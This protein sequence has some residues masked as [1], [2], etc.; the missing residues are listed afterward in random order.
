MAEVTVSGTPL[1]MLYELLVED[2]WRAA[3]YRSDDYQAARDQV[4]IIE[5]IGQ[6]LDREA[7]T[8]QVFAPA[9]ARFNNLFPLDPDDATTDG[10]LRNGND[11]AVHIATGSEASYISLPG[12]LQQFLDR[13]TITFMQPTIV[14][15][16]GGVAQ[17]EDVRDINLR[18]TERGGGSLTMGWDTATNSLLIQIQL[19]AEGEELIGFLDMD[20][21]SMGITIRA[22]PRVDRERLFWSTQVEVNFTPGRRR[23]TEMITGMLRDMLQGYLNESLPELLCY[24]LALPLR[25]LPDENGTVRLSSLGFGSLGDLLELMRRQGV[26]LDAT[27]WGGFTQHFVNAGLLPN[28]PLRAISLTGEIPDISMEFMPGRLM[29]HYVRHV[30]A[31]AVRTLPEI[32][33]AMIFDVEPIGTHDYHDES[34]LQDIVQREKYQ[35]ILD[36]L[37]LD[38]QT[39]SEHAVAGRLTSWRVEWDIQVR[40]PN[41]SRNEWVTIRQKAATVRSSS[42][43]LAL[44]NTALANNWLETGGDMR[45]SGR[46]LTVGHAVTTFVIDHAVTNEIPPG[47]WIELRS[48]SPTVTAVGRMARTSSLNRNELD[49]LRI[50]LRELFVELPGNPLDYFLQRFGHPPV[51]TPAETWLTEQ[52]VQR[53]H[54]FTYLN[55]ER[56]SICN[57]NREAA[58]NMLRGI[59]TTFPAEHSTFDFYCEKDAAATFNLRVV[60]ADI[61]LAG[62][63]TEVLSVAIDVSREDP[64]YPGTE[65][66][67]PYGAPSA[68]ITIEPPGNPLQVSFGIQNRLAPEPALPYLAKPYE[69]IFTSIY[70][71]RD[72][73]ADG[74][75]Y[76]YMGEMDFWAKIW[77]ETNGVRSDEEITKHLV[78]IRA[79]APHT[80]GLPDNVVTFTPSAPVGSI[81]HLSVKGREYDAASR[82]ESMNTAELDLI[83]PTGDGI[84]SEQVS[85]FSG[86]FQFNA[87]ARTASPPPEILFE[88]LDAGTLFDGSYSLS[89]LPN[90]AWAFRY[91][92]SWAQSLAL[93]YSSDGDSWEN[94]DDAALTALFIGEQR[95]VT[96]NAPPTG[97]RGGRYRLAATNAA[98]TTTSKL[99]FLTVS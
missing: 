37:I 20:W 72:R 42:N 22:I 80:E 15:R 54:V 35:I 96:V 4:N 31:P 73:D 14:F 77:T 71:E 47:D 30:N 76:E 82:V 92:V 74:L 13:D 38:P 63:E 39:Y 93:Q 40:H 25:P 99:L 11:L 84:D 9:L 53:L 86:Y 33:P 10:D 44:G 52:I 17:S 12:F 55:G 87:R 62:S 46:V 7:E 88:P 36:H 59:G 94:L 29:D 61:D 8:L 68:R 23:A 95:E 18:P 16:V 24:L 78:Y 19:E 21:T 75:S 28:N 34:Y 64:R 3:A 89:V 66:R 2:R 41:L 97:Q 51:D 90:S 48:I 49:W 70:I 1:Q 43:I 91:G 56:I 60:L 26:G 58:R 81:I 83:V 67:I 32:G 79:A 5:A 27:Q 57:F 69:I 98:G 6:F 85:D 45:I 50:I 65:W